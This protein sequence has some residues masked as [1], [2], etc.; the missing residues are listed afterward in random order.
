[1]S[2]GCVRLTNEDVEDLYRR[3]TVG[4]RVIVLPGANT[5]DL[6][7]STG[8]AAKLDAEEWRDMVLGSMASWRST[9][10]TECSCTLAIR[11]LMRTTLSV[12]YMPDWRSSKRLAKLGSVEP[13]QVR[14]GI[15]T[16]LVVVGDLIGSGAAQEQAVVG[17]TPNVAARLQSM[18]E[19]N[20]IVIAES[21]R[22]LVQV[23]PTGRAC[24][25]ARG[26]GQISLLDCRPNG[27]RP[28][29]AFCV[30]ARPKKHEYLTG[31][32]WGIPAN[33]KLR[34]AIQGEVYPRIFP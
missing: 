4:T 21:T 17:E 28:H 32:I 20:T 29:S 23:Q 18:A 10:A 9:W 1:V 31:F 26:N 15:A 34:R 19:P 8:I 5:C 16:G 30:A 2:S 33:L 12:Q 6:V 13:L 27:I 14:I 24:P 3:V 7:D 11:K 22:K 25:N